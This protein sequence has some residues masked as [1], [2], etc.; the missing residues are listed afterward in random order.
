[1]SA[2]RAKVPQI[3]PLDVDLKLYNGRYWSE[4]LSTQ[5]EIKMQDG[6][7]FAIHQ[8][9]APIE[10][11][12]SAEDAFDVHSN[13]FMYIEFVRDVAGAIQGFKMSHAGANDV[14]FERRP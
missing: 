3:T 10:L 7:L 5:Y 1:M 13:Q 6:R 8:R 4:E 2:Q 12:A 14:W 11:F 9:L